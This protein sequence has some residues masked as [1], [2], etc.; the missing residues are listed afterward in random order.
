MTNN[1]DVTWWVAEALM[2]LTPKRV[3]GVTAG[4]GC[5]HPDTKI[6]TERG[7]VRICDI[8]QGERVLSWNENN[9]KF[10]L[11]P[12]SGGFL[13]G[14][15]Y[16]YRISTKQEEFEVASHHLILSS[17][18]K[19][20][21]ASDLSVGDYLASCSQHPQNSNLAFAPKLFLLNVLNYS[22][23]LLNSL[24]GYL[25][26][27]RLYG[28][29][30]L[31]GVSAYLSKIPLLSDVLRLYQR[32]FCKDDRQGL[33]LERN[34]HDQLI[35]R[36]PKRGYTSR[37]LGLEEAE[38]DRILASP[39]EHTL[40]YPQLL[41]QFLLKSLRHRNAVRLFSVFRSSS[42]SLSKARII[43]IEKQ[44]VKQ[45]YWDIQV[46][47]NNNYVTEGGAIHH[48]SGKTHGAVQ[49]SYET[50]QI[51]KGCQFSFFM[52]PVY[53]LIHSAGI[54]TFRKFFALMGMIEG[55]HYK[56]INS[57]F[58]KIIY[59]NKQE[60]H[61]I[62][63][64]RTDLLI[65]TEFSHGVIS[66][67]G[68]IKRD[69]FDLADTR[70]RK[71]EAKKLQLLL[72][73]VPQ[74]L[75]W[76]ADLFDSSNSEWQ[77]NQ[78]RDYTNDKRNYRR[79]RSTT[80]DNQKYLPESYI[81]S[82]LRTYAG[83]PAYIKSWIYGHFA[84]LVQGSVYYAYN[85]ALHDIENIQ[86]S[87]YREIDLTF[88]FNANPMSFSVIQQAIF[89][90][91]DQRVLKEVIIDEI[92]EGVQNLDDAVV[93]FSLKFPNSTFANTQ[94][95]VYGDSS[96]HAESHKVS[97]SDYKRIK[98]MLNLLGYQNVVIKAIRYNPKEETTAK[99][100][101]D[102]FEKDAL[103]INRK[104]RLLKR[105]LIG[106]VYKEGTRKINK[107]AGETITHMGDSLKYWAYVKHFTTTKAFN[108]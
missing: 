83:R 56:I 12:S 25:I 38:A 107:P 76:Y 54:P 106:T 68:S 34:H 69:A 72:E 18:G 74:G 49:W 19:Y 48:N 84:D 103:L 90:E 9:Q 104:C 98:K 55:R 102:L 93:D 4:L 22:Q 77:E 45:D 82:L 1:I 108:L 15:N 87:P 63:A 52:M 8:K 5:V 32:F 10:E 60:V 89:E 43:S 71:L 6:Q 51:N 62:S 59:A 101:N 21:L 31:L 105:S 35:V 78:P 95:N 50:T 44:K 100:L 81:P 41:K 3:F 85:P 86:A 88:D 99:A 36:K 92:S 20:V 37:A 53:R 46:L 75:N 16:L 57:P 67:A 79:F 26:L 27:S 13:K 17:S 65:A 39:L 40:E 23:K 61:F 24:L 64:T 97:D 29:Q 80:Y 66:E 58:P 47:N 2:D 28:Q 96:G 14:T 7:L 30:F 94:I 70:I 33:E 42:L 11:S 91:H 73:G